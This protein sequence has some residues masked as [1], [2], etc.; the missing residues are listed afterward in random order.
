[1]HSAVPSCSR[2]AHRLSRGPGRPRIGPCPTTH[3][4]RCTRSL[5]V[6]L[7]TRPVGGAPVRAR[8][9]PARCQR[10]PHFPEP[11][12]LSLHS[13]FSRS[14]G[15]QS[16]PGLTTPSIDLSGARHGCADAC[17]SASRAQPRPPL[18]LDSHT[19]PREHAS[20]F[21]R[22]NFL[23]ARPWPSPLRALRAMPCGAGWARPTWRAC[24]SRWLW[25]RCLCWRG[26]R[27][28]LTGGICPSGIEVGMALGPFASRFSGVH[29]T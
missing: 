4:L 16:A 3:A 18:H 11:D 28:A 10:S 9:V 22:P 24:G 14:S 26:G 1:M 13:A 8:A 25:W 7:R 5:P 29:L 6:P 12:D 23:W 20:T 19:P 27:P 17:A 15:K 2:R 21:R